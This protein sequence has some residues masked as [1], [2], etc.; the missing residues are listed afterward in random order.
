MFFSRPIL[1]GECIL[2]C[3]LQCSEVKTEPVIRCGSDFSIDLGRVQEAEA[4][5]LESLVKHDPLTPFMK[6][7][8]GRLEDLDC[9]SYIAFWVERKISFD[10][11]SETTTLSQYFVSPESIDLGGPETF[12]KLARS[13][14]MGSTPVTIDAAAFPEVYRAYAGIS[15]HS[16]ENGSGWTNPFRR[17]SPP[18]YKFGKDGAEYRYWANDP[19][20][21]SVCQITV[22]I[23]RDDQVSTA[24]RRCWRRSN[25]RYWFYVRFQRWGIG[26]NS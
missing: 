11:I 2:L 19:Y 1:I 6:I 20:R 5:L 4:R 7:E 17:Y 16:F 18:S 25:L 23:S 15:S 22:R 24:I 10:K 3:L 21:V 8:T 26:S 14:K 9:G 12:Q 13:L